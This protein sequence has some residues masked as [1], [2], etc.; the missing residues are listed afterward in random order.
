MSIRKSWEFL[1]EVFL[2]LNDEYYF[3]KIMEFKNFKKENI[4]LTY[5]NDNCNKTVLMHSLFSYVLA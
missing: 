4:Y 2:Q 1:I 3:K 5:K